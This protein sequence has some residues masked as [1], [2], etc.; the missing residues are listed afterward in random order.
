MQYNHFLLFSKA[1]LIL[2]HFTMFLRYCRF[3]EFRVCGQPVLIKSKSIHAIALTLCANV[4]PLYHI[5]AII[6]IFHTFHS[7]Y[8]SYGDLLLVIC[9]DNAILWGAMN[10][11]HRRKLRQIFWLLHRAVILSLLS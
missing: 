10:C 6:I 9:D 7:Y 11:G 4:M 8:I 5:L 3:Y 2:L 1:D